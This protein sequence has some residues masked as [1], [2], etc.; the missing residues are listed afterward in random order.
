MSGGSW[1]YSYGKLSGVIEALELDTTLDHRK[2][3]LNDLQKEQRHKLAALLDKVRDALR[4]IEWV[5]SGDSSY[6]SDTIAIKEV[7]SNIGRA[8][9]IELRH[10]DKGLLDEVVAREATVHMED[11]GLSWSILIDAGADHLSLSFGGRLKR[12]LVVDQS[13]SVISTHPKR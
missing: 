6:P 5:D 8:P 3:D 2:L 10:D 11:M 1:D 13:G 4:A 9:A 7:F 12:P